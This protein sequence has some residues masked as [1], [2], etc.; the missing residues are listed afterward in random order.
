MQL[1]VANAS[2][3]VADEYLVRTGIRQVD[4]FNDQVE[5]ALPQNSE[6]GIGR[7]CGYTSLT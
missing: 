3:Y 6:P 2:T 1:T 4:V 7:H 5:R